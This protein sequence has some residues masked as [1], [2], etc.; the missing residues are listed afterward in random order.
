MT[1]PASPRRSPARTVILT[2]LV[3]TLAQAI[4]FVVGAVSTGQYIVLFVL[5]LTTPVA[6]VGG[7]LLGAALHW[8]VGALASR[9]RSGPVSA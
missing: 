5:L 6:A 4:G 3:V 2:S 7:A 1:P 9:R 8:I